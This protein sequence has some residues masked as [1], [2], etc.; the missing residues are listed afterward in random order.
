MFGLLGIFLFVLMY[1]CNAQPAGWRMID[2]F[3]GFR[4]EVSLSSDAS[5]FV[6]QVVSE[7][8]KLGCFGWIQKTMSGNYVGEGRCNKV[9]GPMFQDWLS[10]GE[11]VKNV[12]IKVCCFVL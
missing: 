5:N 6:D 11:I 1:S 10:N 9:K 3:Y 8:D 12:Q 7:A 2:R 4:Y